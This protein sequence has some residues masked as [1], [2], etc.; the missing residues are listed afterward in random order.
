MGKCNSC[1]NRVLYHRKP[2]REPK[3][4]P[5]EQY[6]DL[7]YDAGKMY[8]GWDVQYCPV[9]KKWLCAKCKA[10]PAK[11]AKG[12]LKEKVLRKKVGGSH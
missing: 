4:I 11:R 5:Q 8:Y 3:M 1:L 12:F 6:C 9:C 7:C 10:D 2:D